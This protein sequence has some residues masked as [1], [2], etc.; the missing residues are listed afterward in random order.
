MLK[1]LWLITSTIL[2]VILSAC[3]RDGDKMIGSCKDIHV[4]QELSFGMAYCQGDFYIRYVD[5]DGN[6]RRVT[7]QEEC[8]AIDVVI[9]GNIEEWGQDGEADCTWVEYS[10]PYCAPNK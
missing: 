6:R 10:Q 1:L 2:I 5:Q 9:A 8:E 3:D 4:E 7:S